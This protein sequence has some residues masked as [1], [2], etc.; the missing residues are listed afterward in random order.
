MLYTV[1]VSFREQGLLPSHSFV[2]ALISV[3]RRVLVLTAQIPNLEQ[4]NENSFHHAVVELALLTV[5]IVVGSLIFL[6]RETLG[7]AVPDA[8]Q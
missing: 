7:V 4:S 2:V 6:Q 3:I 1:Q 8:N 5:M